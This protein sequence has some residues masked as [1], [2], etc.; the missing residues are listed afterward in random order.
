MV[1][2]RLRPRFEL[3][4]SRP[5]LTAVADL[6]KEV[7]ASIELEGSVL[8]HAYYM[9]AAQGVRLRCVEPFIEPEN[10]QHFGKLVRDLIPVRIERHG[11][12]PTIYRATP[13]E[14]RPLLREKLLEESF[15]FYW[16]QSNSAALEELADIYDLIDAL[17]EIHG[18]NLAAVRKASEAKRAERGG[19]QQ[20]IVLVETS[21]RRAGASNSQLFGGS[22]PTQRTRARPEKRRPTLSD[23]RITIPLI[24]SSTSPEQRATVIKIGEGTEAAVQYGPADIYVEFRERNGELE[25]GGQLSLLQEDPENGEE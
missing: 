23:R 5:F 21:R 3:L 4:R 1:Q 20:G 16:S 19:F 10:L 8:G 18:G 14:L 11:E 7:D 25:R 2:I 13:E 12:S 24:P 6:A 17:S 15:E 9:L 22:G